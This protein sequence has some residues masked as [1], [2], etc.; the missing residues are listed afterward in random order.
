VAR[1]EDDLLLGEPLEWDAPLFRM[2]EAQLEDALGHAQVGDAIAARL[3]VP[4]RAVMVSV[5]IHLDSGETRVFAAYRVQ[6]S[7]ILGP[8]K[9][10]IRYDPHVSLEIIAG[11]TGQP[12]EKVSRDMERDYFMTAEEAKQYGIIDSVIAHRVGS[13]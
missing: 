3:R 2:A 6:H 9:G 10:G 11:H 12:L 4:E 8:T 5:P 13:E 7:T 1:V